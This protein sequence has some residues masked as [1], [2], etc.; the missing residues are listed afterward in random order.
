MATRK[1]KS[2]SKKQFQLPA[3]PAYE[4]VI[5]PIV[6]VNVA[7]FNEDQK[8]LIIND[9]NKKGYLVSDGLNHA[10]SGTGVYNGFYYEKWCKSDTKVE[11]IN[12]EDDEFCCVKLTENRIRC[13]E[14]T[15]VNVGSTGRYD[16]MVHHDHVTVGC[17]TI[18]K[19]NIIT[20]CE[21]IITAYRE[22]V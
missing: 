9:M 16:V 12:I 18:L 21:K 4:I 13:M 10:R 1:S 3:V 19:D 7:D 14:F 5:D 8:R 2:K 6:S 15:P 11:D 22:M 17:Q 20:I